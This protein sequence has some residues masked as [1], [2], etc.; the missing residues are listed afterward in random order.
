MK[1]DLQ[2]DSETS[3]S[4]IINLVHVPATMNL[5]LWFNTKCTNGTWPSWTPTLSSPD[6]Q[7]IKE[8]RSTIGKYIS[9]TAQNKVAAK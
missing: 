9:C 6:F 7:F 8:T 2:N 1:G 5:T 3:Y 4:K